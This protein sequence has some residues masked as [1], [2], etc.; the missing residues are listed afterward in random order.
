MSKNAPCG[1]RSDVEC[2]L[3]DCSFTTH[4]D[5]GVKQHIGRGHSMAERKQ[6]LQRDLRIF[7]KSLGRTPTKKD[8]VG[9]GPWDHTVYQDV[10]GSWN[11][12]LENAG[13]ELNHVVNV[14]DDELLAEIARVA[15]VLGHPPT[16]DEMVAHGQFDASTY[17][18]RFGT[19]ATALEKTGFGPSKVSTVTTQELIDDIH[20][21]AKRLE[22]APRCHEMTIY[23]RHGAGSYYNHFK[24][25]NGALTI[26][27]FETYETPC[28]VDHPNWNGGTFP[29]GPGWN[30][31]KKEQI[32]ERDGRECQSCGRSEEEHI[33]LYDKKHTVHHIQKARNFDD[34]EQRN[35]PDNL[36]TLCE[37]GECHHKWEMMAPL[38]PQVVADD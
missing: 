34:P 33:E 13:L 18:N 9:S 1:N 16:Y 8:M 28:G 2:P 36:I 29:Y 30:D 27:G 3:A 20:R 19:W 7:A 11:A 32:R 26:A 4:S 31:A 24:T 12:A 15:D 38:R 6:I 35:H 5:Y 37:T 22:R 23:G 21:V 10:Y 17:E 25:W 14:P